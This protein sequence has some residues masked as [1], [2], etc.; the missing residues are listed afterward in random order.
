MLVTK[1]I[2][3]DLYLNGVAVEAF[4]HLSRLDKV[5]NI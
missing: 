5:A 4:V 1:I 3:H 2:E